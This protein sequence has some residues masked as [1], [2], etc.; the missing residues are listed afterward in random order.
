MAGLLDQAQL[1]GSGE[2]LAGAE[3]MAAYFCARARRVVAVNGTEHWLRVLDTEFGG[4]NEV[5]AV[6]CRDSCSVQGLVFLLLNSS[7]SSSSS[8]GR[9]RL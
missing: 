2:A 3:A 5:R 8:S 7:G 4:M 9:L 1:A 6:G